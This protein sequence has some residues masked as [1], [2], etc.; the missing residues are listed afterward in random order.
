M[1][2]IQLCNFGCLSSNGS[3]LHKPFASC[4]FTVMFLMNLDAIGEDPEGAFSPS[5][6]VGEEGSKTKEEAASCWH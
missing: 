5:G 2:R 6:I 3:G 1:Y 4:V